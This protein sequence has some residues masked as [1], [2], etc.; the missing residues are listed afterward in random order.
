[1]VL[2]KISLFI[3][4]KDKFF[5]HSYLLVAESVCIS[6]AKATIERLYV[7]WE[8]VSDLLE[9]CNFKFMRLSF[10]L[11]AKRLEDAIRAHHDGTIW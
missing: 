1:M 2:A 9:T 5:W 4:D 8:Q 7:L 3:D 10:K 11:T 6:V